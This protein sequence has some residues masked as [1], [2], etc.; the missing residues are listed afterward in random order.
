MPQEAQQQGESLITRAVL[1]QQQQ[2][3]SSGVCLVSAEEKGQPGSA[4][5]W[6]NA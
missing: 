5:M 3:N 1:A 2:K 6:R 4:D